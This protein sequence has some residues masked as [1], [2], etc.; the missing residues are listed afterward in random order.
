M[1]EENYWIQ[2][3]R[4]QRSRRSVLRGAAL[5]G[6]GL[7]GMAML[8]CKAAP[9]GTSKSSGGQSTTAPPADVNAL[10][11]RT[12][13][14]P[15]QNET[16][17][18]GGTYNYY[19]NGNPPVLDPDFSVSALAFGPIS[20][21]M[22]RPFAFKRTWNVAD[23]YNHELVPDLAMTAE[24]PDALTWTLKLRQGVNF[25]NV[26]PVSGHAVEAEDFKATFTRRTDPKSANRGSVAMI[27]AAQIQ[28]PDKQT[29]VFKLKYPYAPFQTQLANNQ[30]GWILPREALAGTYDPGK[31]IIGSG[32][33][34]WGG[35]TPDV[36][37]TFKKNPDYYV[38]GHPYVD[39]VRLSIIPDPAQRLAQ[40]TGGHLDYLSVPTDDDYPAAS[41]QNPKAETIRAWD[42]GDGHVYFQLRDPKSPFQD[43]R[44]RQAVSLAIDRE[45]YG[46][47]MLQDKYVQGFFIP[48]SWGKWALR[49]PEL[50]ADVQSLYHVDLNH[51]NDML[52]AYLPKE[53]IVINADLYGPPAQGAAPPATVAPNAIAFYRNLKRLKLDVAVHVPIHGN[54]GPNADFER[55]VGPAA[56]RAPATGYGG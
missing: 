17:V 28:T 34:L 1:N 37:A 20:A 29:V 10:I 5:A 39:E 27:D 22:S 54:P 7:A 43:I 30:Y 50:P 26:A 24:S 53:K 33:F 14:P 36:A 47:A 6:A 23:S 18:M 52:I 51:A 35:V 46:K 4:R 15:A 9:T 55:I 41:Q 44:M 45:A 2:A 48:Q 49:L 32:P 25:H 12:G 11:G 42:P 19:Q 16:P 31:T 38:K 56:A 8:A 13:S 40:F 21:V 3:M